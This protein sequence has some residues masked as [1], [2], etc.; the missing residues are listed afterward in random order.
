MRCVITERSISRKH[1]KFIVQTKAVQICDLNSGNGSYVNDQKSQQVCLRHGDRLRVGDSDFVYTVSDTDSTS[2]SVNTL[3]EVTEVTKLSK[4][5]ADTP[6]G[7][8]RAPSSTNRFLSLSFFII[9]GAAI[10]LL[11][12]KWFE[13]EKENQQI[14]LERNR[15]EDLY[16]VVMSSSAGNFSY[17]N[18]K[19]KQVEPELK[20]SFLFEQAK[21]FVLFSIEFEKAETY[22]NEGQWT[23]A[24]ETLKALDLSGVWQEPLS[25]L[26]QK[27]NKRLQAWEKQLFL[28]LQKDF[29]RALEQQD[30]TKARELL[31]KLGASSIAGGSLSPMKVQL[32]SLLTSNEEGS[33]G[34][35]LTEKPT[36]EVITAPVKR[37]LTEAKAQQEFS[38]SLQLFRTGSDGQACQ[39]LRQLITRTP[40]QSIW[41]EKAKS[42]L[43]RKCRR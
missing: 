36:K 8:M 27:K 33:K 16:D 25:S 41:R 1:A 6:K 2:V 38:R 20:N 3:P 26:K 29:V 10:G 22:A 4:W 13:Y 19:L 24:L 32:E 37:L 9:L 11:G 35:Q 43:S 40:S 28:T 31:D 42:F 30:K 17:A 23:E 12:A 7:D 15:L 5:R 18:A 21:S 39:N 14:V 34:V